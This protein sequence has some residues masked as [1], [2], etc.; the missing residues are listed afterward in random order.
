MAAMQISEQ[1]RGEKLGAVADSRDNRGHL[2]TP[3][4]TPMLEPRANVTAEKLRNQ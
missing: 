1:L 2:G 3:H 4:L